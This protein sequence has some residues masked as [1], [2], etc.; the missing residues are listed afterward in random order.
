MERLTVALPTVSD[1]YAIP[2][3]PQPKYDRAPLSPA[4]RSAF[5][6]MAGNFYTT[7]AE[8]PFDPIEAARRSVDEALGT[9]EAAPLLAERDA[10]RRTIDL[11]APV[12]AFDPTFIDTM[13]EKAANQ[14]R[15]SAEVLQQ[16]DLQARRYIVDAT[17]LLERCQGFH[18]KSVNE[19][20]TS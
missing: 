14:A 12:E 9:S 13:A 3:F 2:A 6:E 7:S 19:R 11:A 8:D 4:D 15:P 1:T 10:D 17:A 16:S 20:P 18:L 5:A